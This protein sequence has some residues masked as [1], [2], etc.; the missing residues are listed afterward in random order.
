[1]DG[2]AVEPAPGDDVLIAGLRGEPALNGTRGVVQ[3]RENWPHDRG[4]IAV[5]LADAKPARVI[6]LKASNIQPWSPACFI[7]LERD[8][9]GARPLPLGCG[10]RGSSGWAHAACAIHAAAAQQERAG[11]WAGR[12]RFPWQ[13][14]PT[15]KLPYS[16]GLKLVLA[17]EWCR[18]TEHLADTQRFAARTSLGNALSSDGQWR[19]AEAVVRSNLEASVALH[20]AEHRHSLGTKMN[21]A[22]LLGNQGKHDEAE[23]MYASLL[24]TQLVW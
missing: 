23:A 20:G 2:T 11:D 3:P 24:E 10:C 12:G 7:C 15:C 1:M 19:E 21:L 8:L 6:A 9:D 5:L 16:G 13:L 17:R 14:C 4:R 18:R 22:L